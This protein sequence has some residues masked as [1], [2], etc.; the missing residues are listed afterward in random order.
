MKIWICTT[1]IGTVPINYLPFGSM[2]IIRALRKVWEK[3]I[4]TILTIFVIVT[5]KLRPIF[6]NIS[7]M[8]SELTPSF[9]QPIPR[10]MAEI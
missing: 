9:R 8:W 5:K 1:P 6:E 7:L 3:R 2:A 4:F 10:N